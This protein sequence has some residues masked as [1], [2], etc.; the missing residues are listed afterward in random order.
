M[1]QKPHASLTTKQAVTRTAS[2]LNPAVVSLLAGVLAIIAALVG[3]ATPLH[4]SPIPPEHVPVFNDVSNIHFTPDQYLRPA[5]DNLIGAAQQQLCH[6]YYFHNQS[7]NVGFDGN[8]SIANTTAPPAGAPSQAEATLPPRLLSISPITFVEVAKFYSDPV[9]PAKFSLTGDIVASIWL[10]TSDFQNTIFRAEM[11]TYNP[12]D[13]STGLLDDLDFEIITDGQNEALLI[14]TAPAVTIPAGHRF[15]LKLF[16]GNE[17][18]VLGGNIMV[19]LFYD[20]AD[21]ASNFKVCQIPPPSLTISK[22]G[23]ATAIAGQPISYTLTVMNSG[24]LPATNLVIGDTVPAGASYVS[25]G[26]ESGGVVTWPV[27]ASL[28]PNTSIQRSFVVM[29][30]DTI[31]NEDY[32]VSADDNVS[33]VGQ[34]DVV[35]VV[36]QP[37][38]PN[39][40]ISKS[41][42]AIAKPGEPIN[43][44]LTVFNGGDT[45]A[46]NLVIS[47]TLPAGATYVGGGNLSGNTVTW[48]KDSLAANDS[49]QFTLVV[50][51]E[52]TITNDDYRV[53]AAGNILAVGEEAV[54]TVIAV[55]PTYLPMLIKP[56]PITTLMI[57]SQNTGGINPLRVLDL[58]N[59]EL[60]TCTIGN[61]VVQLCG[62][63]P[64][65]GNYKII[66]HTTNC[67][68]LQGTFGDASPGA[69]V[70]RRIFCN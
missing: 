27:V 34:Q 37:G 15:L 58:G 32:G 8:Q 66:A 35:T 31:V 38:Q 33:A 43:Y 20:S 4:A 49:E 51:A 53:R 60:L 1:P 65:V 29:A 69:T 40:S 64:A 68:V 45:Q 12:A 3:R 19:T 54:T 50:T 55:P 23:P 46:T 10:Q 24:G 13:G 16:A 41:G 11:V 67:G 14:F 7:Q 70:T 6:T 47:D 30:T 39:L 25:G 42:P 18:T 21:R 28:A 26:S 52:E 36:S 61:N 57:D 63:F 5:V 56:G 2:P 62:T 17:K 22:S 59:H 9:L 44:T 48:T